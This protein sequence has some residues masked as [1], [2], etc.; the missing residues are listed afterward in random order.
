MRTLTKRQQEVLNAIVDFIEGHGYP[1]TVREL[2]DVV[3][4]GSTN[5]VSDHL[6]ALERK[7]HLRIEPY[8]HRGLHP[9]GLR[10]WRTRALKAEAEVMKLRAEIAKLR[11]DVPESEPVCPG[12]GGH[13]VLPCPV[14][15]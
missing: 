12:C 9:V 4:I 6:R 14:C 2:G 1:P 10:D 13:V 15:S 7:G 11:G 8:I 3:G 5:G